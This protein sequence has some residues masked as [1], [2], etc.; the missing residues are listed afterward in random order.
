MLLRGAKSSLIILSRVFDSQF[1]FSLELSVFSVFL[2]K[3]FK[4]SMDLD[5]PV[6]FA[7]PQE[8][9]SAT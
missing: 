3:R 9:I 6:P 1:V 4:M 5:A 2:I 8:A 7:A